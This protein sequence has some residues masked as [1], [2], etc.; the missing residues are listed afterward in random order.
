MPCHKGVNGGLVS[1]LMHFALAAAPCLLFLLA[2]RGAQTAGPD[3]LSAI[4]T[5]LEA[6]RYRDALTKARR[7]VRENSGDALAWTYVGMAS[8]RLGEREAAL[9]AFERAIALSPR[10]PRPFFDAALLYASRNNLD[11]AVDRYQR[12]LAIDTSNETAQFN[13]GRLLLLKGRAEEAER[14]FLRTLEINPR[15]AGARVELSR[16]ALARNDF[17]RA[18]DFAR[19]A[20]DLSPESLEANLALAEAYISSHHDVQ[21]VGHLEKLMPRFNQSAALHYTLGI[22]QYRSKQFHSAVASFRKAVELDPRLDLAQFLL[23]SAL[24][25]TG[26]LDGAESGFKA[27]IAIRPDQPLYRNYLARVY[28]QRGPDYRAAARAATKEVL[29]LNPADVEGRRRMAQWAKDDG[30]LPR[31]RQLLEEV[32]R[33]EPSYSPARVQ[34]AVVYH[35]LRL[36][37]KAEEQEQAVRRLE[38]E[39]QSGRRAPYTLE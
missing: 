37:E 21:A 15:D 23:A 18:I 20:A 36:R 10:D 33:D 38:A 1:L 14:A 6:N 13:Y 11:Q 27:A 30:D 12:G 22:A 19:Q 25:G 3:T 31:A 32:V 17:N 26:D 8:V 5:D 28:D 29:R 39:G 24:L 4:A 35:R 2:A 34:L 16:L 7:R 9:E